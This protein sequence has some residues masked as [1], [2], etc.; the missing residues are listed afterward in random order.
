MSIAGKGIIMSL[1]SCIFTHA[2]GSLQ[3]WLWYFPH[4]FILPGVLE[5]PCLAASAYWLLLLPVAGSG[6]DVKW[7]KVV[8]IAY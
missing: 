7:S 6:E 8:D 3:S 5:T 2:R 4:R 1:S